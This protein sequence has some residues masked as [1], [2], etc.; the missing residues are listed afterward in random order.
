MNKLSSS[1]ES[2]ENTPIAKRPFPSLD[3]LLP[4]HTVNKRLDNVAKQLVK[5]KLTIETDCQ[6]SRPNHP[7]RPSGHNTRPTQFSRPSGYNTRPSQFNRPLGH[8]TRPSQFNRHASPRK[9]NRRQQ[10]HSPKYKLGHSR[11][12]STNEPLQIKGHQVNLR[13]RIRRHK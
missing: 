6:P 11:Q 4:N 5:P 2:L 3:T 13:P 8:N 9:K 1:C 12:I 10:S 7:P